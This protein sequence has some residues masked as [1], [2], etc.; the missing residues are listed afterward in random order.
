MTETHAI[1]FV[2]SLGL[3][4]MVPYIIA[5]Y[6]VTLSCESWALGHRFESLAMFAVD[7]VIVLAYTNS[8]LTI[9]G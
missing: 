1:A 5:A 4:A 6:V 7:A 2:L 3:M 9:I 8:L